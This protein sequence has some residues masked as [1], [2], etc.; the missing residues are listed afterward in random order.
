MKKFFFLLLTTLA[1]VACEGPV[2]PSG[3][4]GPGTQWN[5]EYVEVQP[6]DWQRIS[7]PNNPNEIYYRYVRKFQNIKDS[8]TL[9]YIYDNGKTSAFLYHN[10]DPSGNNPDETQTSLPYVLN[11]NDKFNNPYTETWYYDYSIEDIAF[12]VAYSGDVQTSPGY[13]VFRVVMNW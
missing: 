7:N 5:I 3:P 12:Y 6:G 9:T 11:L 2:G 4:P 8:K 1:L 10:Y 13:A